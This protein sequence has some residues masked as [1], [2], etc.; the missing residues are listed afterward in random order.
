MYI[1]KFPADVMAAANATVLPA[2]YQS[3]ISHARRLEYCLSILYPTR[4]RSKHGASR[5]RGYVT[6]FKMASMPKCLMS[7]HK[8]FLKYL[9]PDKDAQE[10]VG[11][12]DIF[13]TGYDLHGWPS[14]PYAQSWS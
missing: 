1:D 11:S 10:L 12:S 14:V 5:S 13:R 4:Y 2:Y 9:H 8:A 6:R 7:N 3:T